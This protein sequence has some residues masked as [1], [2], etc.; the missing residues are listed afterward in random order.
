MHCPPCQIEL[1]HSRVGPWKHQTQNAAA[2]NLEWRIAVHHGRGQ[3]PQILA[4]FVLRKLFIY[5]M[6]RME[7]CGHLTQ[8]GNSTFPFTTMGDGFWPVICAAT[9]L[10][11]TCE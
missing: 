3:I 4:D 6:L 10:L 8:K 7:N 1:S 9:L 5:K 11:M 2:W